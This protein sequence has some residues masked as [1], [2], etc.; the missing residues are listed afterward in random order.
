MNI[1]SKRM[2]AI[3]RRHDDLTTLAREFVD[4]QKN[5]GRRGRLQISDSGISEYVNTACHC[6]PEYDWIDRCTLEDFEIGRASCRE[7][8]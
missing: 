2:E 1:T 4:S 3:I 6:H 8:V 7:R 5:E